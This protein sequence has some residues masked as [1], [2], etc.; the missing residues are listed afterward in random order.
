[1]DQMAERV[2][3]SSVTAT[4][5]TVGVAVGGS[6]VVVAVGGTG[7]SVGVGVGSDAT[8]HVQVRVLE[9]DAGVD[10]RSVHVYP[11]VIS[12]VNVDCGLVAAHMRLMPVGPVWAL[13]LPS[14]SSTM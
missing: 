5:V 10:H 7:V 14:M 13:M 11:P 8:G 12:T 4:G 2:G 9:V 3:T 1:M 6:V